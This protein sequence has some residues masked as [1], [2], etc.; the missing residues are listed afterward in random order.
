MYRHESRD[1]IR[2]SV[3]A[4]E[5]DAVIFVG[6]G[7]TGAVHKLVHGLGN[8]SLTV[9]V[10]IQEHHSSLL[11]WREAGAEIVFVQELGKISRRFL[12]DCFIT[13]FSISF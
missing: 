6:H 9:F 7:A 10:S 8:Q 1:I 13:H 2:N 3:N 5:H 4:S 12:T 11:P